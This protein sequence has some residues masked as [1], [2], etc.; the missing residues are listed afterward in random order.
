MIPVRAVLL[1][2]FYTPAAR[3]AAVQY[4]TD[5][6]QVQSSGTTIAPDHAFGLFD[7]EVFSPA[8]PADSSAAQTSSVAAE[9]VRFSSRVTGGQGLGLSFMIVLF[10]VTEPA[11]WQAAGG[12]SLLGESGFA[13]VSLVSL[14][15][16]TTLL[17]NEIAGDPPAASIIRTW[18]A[19]GVLA[20]GDYELEAIIHSGGTGQPHT[21]SMEMTFTVP[22]PGTGFCLLAF[23]AA[24]LWQRGRRTGF[25]FCNYAQRQH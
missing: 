18:S 11:A 22:E 17:L 8:N 21:G 9:A 20:P 23:A 25:D 19:A 2:M 15:Q 14:P 10:R 12:F 16:R 6:R 7:A 3:A 13:C 1:L 4:L 5:T 24:A